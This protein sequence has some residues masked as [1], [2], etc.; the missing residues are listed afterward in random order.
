MQNDDTC[1]DLS[2][3]VQAQLVARAAAKIIPARNVK[4]ITSHARYGEM[5]TLNIGLV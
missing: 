4:L 1:P 5:I 3:Q 2:G